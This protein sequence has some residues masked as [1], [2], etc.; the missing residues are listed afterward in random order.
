MGMIAPDTGETGQAMQAKHE[1]T[2]INRMRKQK[3]MKPLPNFDIKRAFNNW[4][5]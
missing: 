1:R 5:N 2:V 3:K 4:S